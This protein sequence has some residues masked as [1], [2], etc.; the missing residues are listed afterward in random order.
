MKSIT[1]LYPFFKKPTH[2]HELYLYNLFLIIDYEPKLRLEILH[3]IFTKLII[4]D[5]NA[6]REEIE[7]AEE[8]GVD[9]FEMDVEEDDSISNRLKHTVAHT[10]D[11]C[12]DKVLNYLI[13]E[14]HDLQKGEIDWEKTKNM[15]HDIISVFDSVILPTYNIHH[16]QFV[17]F[18]FCSFKSTLTEGFLNYL[19]KKVCSPNVASVYRQTAV[20]YI[21]SLVARATFVPIM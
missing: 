12:M 6:P 19:W 17:M 1:N 18:M 2:Y 21:A 3:L 13:L 8:D 10:L 11:I 14:C 15:Y 4:L 9:V 16:V 5:V 20:S 7:S